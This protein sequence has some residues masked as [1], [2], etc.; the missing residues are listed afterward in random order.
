MEKRT[1]E[2]PMDFEWQSR[3]PGDASS[4]FYQIGMQHHDNKKRTHSVF[5][6]PGKKPL[7]SLRPPNSQPFLFSRSNTQPES[8]V[9][10]S[11]FGQPAFT[12]S[13]FT[14]P[15]KFDPDLS[16]G[17]ENFSSPDNA[18]NE[19]TPE[20]SSPRRNSLFNI[21]GRFAPSPG[22][23]EIPRLN[24][25]SNALVRRVQ[26]RRRRNKELG[27][28][29]QIDTDDDESDR[30]SSREGRTDKSRNKGK[31]SESKSSTA[32]SW[33]TMAWWSEFFK[34][35]EEHPNVPSILSW[36][37]QL[38]VNLA[39]FSLALYVVFAFIS[40]MRREFNIAADN[41]S[42]A[43]ITSMG[44][45]ANNFRI[46]NCELRPPDLQLKCEQWLNCM[47]Q[48]PSRVAQA[49]VSAHAMAEIIN[50]FIEPIS[51]KAIM[52]FLASLATVTVISNWTFRSFR[53]HLSQE[54][55]VRHNYPPA[56]HY[57]SMHA[58]Q[59]QLQHNP[60]HGYFAPH[61]PQQL[62]SNGHAEKNDAPLALEDVPSMDFVT[63]RTRDR[64][65][66]LRT[67]SPSKR[68]RQF[69]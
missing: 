2:S 5:D 25:Y 15:R 41:A 7:P 21:Y 36:W 59:P 18:D 32:P 52:F 39:L 62:Q 26:K 20:Q 65:S 35:L 24:N 12:K 3:P 66:H 50:N 8:Q 61:A 13:A 10:R 22:R 16:S 49:K 31:R 68:H 9:P 63:E 48:D 42:A 4:P 51:W 56:H 69:A 44:V 1:G 14:T 53:N 57:S 43:M 19:D 30:P 28:H 40:T 64:E 38:L 34:L 37:A 6:S 11:V 55:Y 58:T 47:N 46:N 27:R 29:I 67:P 45:C 33:W 54:D 60:S 17:A 23:G